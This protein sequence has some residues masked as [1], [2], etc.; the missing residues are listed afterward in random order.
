LDGSLDNH[1]LSTMP[2]APT[3]ILAEYERRGSPAVTPAV[4]SEVAAALNL[5]PRTVERVLYNLPPSPRPAA[6]PVPETTTMPPLNPVTAPEAAPDP[7]P[8]ADARPLAMALLPAA[9]PAW[10]FANLSWDTVRDLAAAVDLLEVDLRYGVP[11]SDC[12]KLAS[13]LGIQPQSIGTYA[14]ALRK[15]CGIEFVSVHK[16]KATASA[17][18]PEAATAAAPSP[19]AVAPPTP[20][21]VAV[22][23]EPPAGLAPEHQAVWRAWVAAGYSPSE[24]VGW[25]DKE[26]L[27]IGLQTAAGKV[28]QA[29]RAWLELLGLPFPKAPDQQG[30][31]GQAPAVQ[32]GAAPPETV[33]ENQAP[34]TEQLEPAP[35]PEILPD[36]GHIAHVPQ[37]PTCQHC[38]GLGVA[39]GCPDCGKLTREELE[40]RHHNLTTQWNQLASIITRAYHETF[41]AEPC[42]LAN[43]VM[44]LQRDAVAR[45]ENLRQLLDPKPTDLRN[46][47]KEPGHQWYELTLSERIEWLR[48]EH[49]EAAQA[50]IRLKEQLNAADFDLRR[51]GRLLQDAGRDTAGETLTESLTALIRERDAAQQHA[52]DLARRV[53]E[54][55]AHPSPAPTSAT[56]ELRRLQRE[57]VGLAGLVAAHTVRRTL[58][59]E[60]E[61][62]PL[63]TARLAA[64]LHGAGE[65]VAMLAALE[66]DGG[67]S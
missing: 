43:A 52:S 35:A 65:V 40:T 47:L 59:E 56:A 44:E 21:P 23:G 39:D 16:P 30:A 45:S 2:K 57:E 13:A 48:E 15:A 27:A 37:P 46:T 24:Y 3:R 33:R 49:Y 9:P 32:Q 42:G 11:K 66:G 38:A 53:N 36:G 41:D 5:H 61:D 26:R 22:A 67:Q 58:L 51:C 28:H 1:A 50:T 17:P 55:H 6:A 62:C 54:L 19:P 12:A 60:L 4:V 14:T 64:V 20:E 63:A 7:V 10:W 18:M 31:K 25:H 34:A 8:V 29:Q